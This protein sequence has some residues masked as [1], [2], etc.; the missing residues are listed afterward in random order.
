VTRRIA[1][2]EQERDVILVGTR[3]EVPIMHRGLKKPLL[4][5]VAPGKMVVGHDVHTD[6]ELQV[7]DTVTLL[8]KEFEVS[9]LH[10]QRGS[11]DDVT[12]WIDLAQAQE[13]LDMQNLIHAIL[14]LEC[15]CAGD[16]IS[17]IREEIAGILPGT[18]VV[19]RYSAALARAE[20]RAKA[21]QTAEAALAAEVKAG[22]E[23]LAR[24]QQSRQ[25]HVDR[26]AA[27]A[28]LVVPF[29][30]AASV[31]L[32]SLLAFVNARQRQGEIGIL[33]AIGLTSQ[34]I[35]GAL[36]GKA[37]L[38]G[39]IGGL[40]GCLVGVLLGCLVGVLIVKGLDGGMRHLQADQVSEVWSA[41]IGSRTVV[42]TLLLAPVLATLLSGLATWIPSLL[43]ARRDPALILQAD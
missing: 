2:P 26:R 16:R 20:A 31:A 7:G 42:T 21:K 37:V 6:L 33:R 13:L 12:I 35:L 40:L 43:A 8:G 41:V 28:M 17:V 3:G 11:T 9:T 23:L 34:Q 25:K 15:E 10:P 19:E 22:E 27:T 18:Q 24:E 4:D 38:M 1:W 39:L 36:L 32:V 5:A 29:V 14:A 30:I